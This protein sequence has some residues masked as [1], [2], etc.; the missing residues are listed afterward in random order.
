MKTAGRYRKA[1]ILALLLLNT[2]GARVV[3]V[4]DVCQS[5]RVYFSPARSLRAI[6]KLVS[7]RESRPRTPRAFGSAKSRYSSLEIERLCRDDRL[8]MV[9]ILPPVHVVLPDESSR[10]RPVYAWQAPKDRSPVGPPLLV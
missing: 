5:S 6:V 4:T 8:A 7:R 1:L 10:L 3:S 2:S 9:V